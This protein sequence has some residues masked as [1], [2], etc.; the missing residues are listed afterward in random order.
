MK[1]E[2]ALTLPSPGQPWSWDQRPFSLEGTG[3]SKLLR[4][5]EKEGRCEGLDG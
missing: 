5:G 2:S 4:G 1:V 3:Q